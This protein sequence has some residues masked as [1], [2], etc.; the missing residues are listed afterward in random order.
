MRQLIP[1]LLTV[2]MLLGIASYAGAFTMAE[3]VVIADELVAIARVPAGGFSAQERID[4]VNNRLR[5]IY[6]YE[7]LNPSNVRAVAVGATRVI[8][9]GNTPLMT[10]TP[11]DA[12]ANNTTVQ[13]LTLDWL[14]N[15]RSALPQARPLPHIPG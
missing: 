8:M 14:D 3:K 12:A 11:R 4:E 13:H 7:P 10:I 1:T 6:G 2:V 15:M 5:Y 9:V